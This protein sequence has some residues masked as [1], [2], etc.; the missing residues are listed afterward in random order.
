MESWCRFQWYFVNCNTDLKV[1][2]SLNHKLMYKMTT[3]E[4]CTW[5]SLSWDKRNCIT[6]W[7]QFVWGFDISPKNISE[8]Y[9]LFSC[10]PYWQK[11]CVAFSVIE[12]LSLCSFNTLRPRQNG[13]DFADDILKSI[14]LKENVLISLKISFVAKVWIKNIPALVQIMAWRWPGDNPLSEPV[15]VRLLMHICVIRPQWVKL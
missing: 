11:T 2:Y 12:V 7:N 15:M 6:K 14:F 10:H 5:Y 4:F 3:I 1:I 9:D 13:R 8:W